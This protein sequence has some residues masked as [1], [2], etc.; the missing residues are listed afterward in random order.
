MAVNITLKQLRAFVAVARTGSFTAAAENLFITQSALSGLIRDLEQM[1]GMR[2]FDRNTR[3]VVLSD[4]GQSVFA[5]IAK[6][7][8][9]LDGIVAEI[10]QLKKL[11]RG[12]VRVAAS[13]LLSSTL[14]PNLIVEFKRRH[15]DVQITLV[16]VPVETVTA[17]VFA[18]EVDI[19]LGP[20]R[21][22]NS[23]ID[24]VKWFELPFMAVLPPGHPLER[25]HQLKWKDLGS[26]PF[27][28][29]QGQFSYQLAHDVG[30]NWP[31]HKQAVQEVQFMSTALAMVRA[32]LG[33][34][35][36]IPY[37]PELIQQYGLLLRP[38]EQPEVG[39]SFYIFKRR[40]KALTPAAQTFFDFL[41]EQ[42]S[43]IGAESGGVGQPL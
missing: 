40:A 41:Q 19:G 20:E 11:Q 32:G 38:L 14:M 26:F 35:V 17:R 24:E 1:L 21:E 18:Q 23:D 43:F 6:V 25:W 37:I 29:L 30:R 22:Q 10:G 12:V 8:D 5:R 2:L 3:K 39:R 16:D 27:I 9:D 4:A 13:Q 34:S 36:C 33:V 31:G 15:P 42:A 28:C 7:L